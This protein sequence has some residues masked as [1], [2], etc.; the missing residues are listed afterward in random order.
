M[1][2]NKWIPNTVASMPPKDR[3]TWDRGVAINLDTKP[4][5]V[6]K[7]VPSNRTRTS[8][9]NGQNTMAG[10]IA[11]KDFATAGGTLSGILMTQFLRIM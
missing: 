2:Q 5:I 9:P 6:S 11:A 1:D 8:Q 3:P 7:P 10:V 4:K